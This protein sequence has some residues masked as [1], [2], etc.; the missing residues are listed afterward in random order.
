MITARLGHKGSLYKQRRQTDASAILNPFNALRLIFRT[1]CFETGAG[2]E[3]SLSEPH[4]VS[5]SS[6][7]AISRR[8]R[9]V[10]DTY[11]HLHAEWK[12]L[13]CLALSQH[14]SFCSSSWRLCSQGLSSPV[15]QPAQGSDL[16]NLRKSSD[17]LTQNIRVAAYGNT[18][19]KWQ[20]YKK[21]GGSTVLKNS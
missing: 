20:R 15:P 12:C 1:Q 16:V 7:S 10:D 6:Q 8:L 2:G 14:G 5:V 9:G 11:V 4:S 17:P 13:L 21:S 3:A 18:V 19:L